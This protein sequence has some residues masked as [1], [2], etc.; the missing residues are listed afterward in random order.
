MA[1]NME[2]PISTCAKN[3][4][5]C[6]S[7]YASKM[8][9]GV[10]WPCVSTPQTATMTYSTEREVTDRRTTLLTRGASAKCSCLY[11]GTATWWQKREFSTMDH[12]RGSSQTPRRPCPKRSA[13]S[14]S[15]AS[16]WSGSALP[17][18][19][20]SASSQSAP[21]TM[22]HVTKTKLRGETAIK[23]LRDDKSRLAQAG[24]AAAMIA[25]VRCQSERHPKMEGSTRGN[26]SAKSFKY[27][28]R[29]QRVSM[30][31]MQ[32]SIVPTAGPRTTMALSA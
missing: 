15:S 27:A 1:K 4:A 7:G 9:S 25:N 3:A 10:F 29:P 28:A 12:A 32:A 31:I 23:R 8:F 14:E 18:L 5:L 30:S 19:T 26:K 11:T 21:P 20:G 22:R 2:Q 13:F 16:A 6:P 24:K 17:V